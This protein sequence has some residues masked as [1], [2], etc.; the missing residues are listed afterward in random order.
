VGVLAPTAYV[1]QAGERRSTRIES[2]RALSALAVVVSHAWSFTQGVHFETYHSRMILGLGV[3]GVDTFFALTGYLIFLPFARRD[4]GG[5]RRVDLGGYA[6]NRALRILPLYYVVLVV[7]AVIDGVALTEFLR[8]ALFGENFREALVGKAIDGP[9]WS[10]VVELH[11]YLLL[12][13]LAWGV[14]RLSRGCVARAA[15]LLL[16]LAAGSVV[17]FEIASRP[18]DFVWLYS[19]PANFLFFVPGMLLAIARAKLDTHVPRWLRHPLA[20]G[21]LWLLAA[22]AI[23]LLVFID[24]QL[25]YRLL[26]LCALGTLLVVATCTLPVRRSGLDRVLDLRPLALLGIASYSLYLWHTRILGWLP[27]HTVSGWAECLVLIAISLPICVLVS[28]ASYRLIE[29]PPLRLRRRWFAGSTAP[30]A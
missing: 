10:L 2:L 4:Y 7:L 18:N 15:L 17:V 6:L 3:I 8:F 21:D 13:L 14:A 5:G 28:F 20:R 12:P 24:A 19:L 9:M 29:Y 16:G 23:W 27:H 22:A 26:P 11:F 30:Q 25:W 1:T